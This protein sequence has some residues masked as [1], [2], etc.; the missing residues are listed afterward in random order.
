MPGLKRYVGCIDRGRRT[1]RVV[2]CLENGICPNPCR[3][4]NGNS[5]RN[6]MW[7][8]NFYAIPQYEKRRSKKVPRSSPRSTGE[9]N[10][11]SRFRAEGEEMTPPNH[12]ERQIME[13]LHRA[14]WVKALT[15]PSSPKVICPGDGF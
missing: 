13:R 11:T 6:S 9:T 14:G 15:L 8:M 5:T 2:Y 4:P 1:D 12:L 3:V 10:D 7:P